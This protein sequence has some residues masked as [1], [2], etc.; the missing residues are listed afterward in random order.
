MRGPLVLA[1][2]AAAVAGWLYAHRNPSACPYSQRWLLKFP[3][4]FLTPGPVLSVLAPKPGERIL[5]IGPGTG[6][7][8]FAVAEALGSDGTLAIFD[9]QQQMLDD[10]MAEA[11]ERGVTNIEPRQGDATQLPYEDA[12]FDGAFLVTVLGEIPDG[13][14]TLRELHRV[15]KPGGRVVF[16]ETILD[17]H[18]VFPGDLRRR[19]E[20]AGF[21]H[22]HQQGIAPLGWLDRCVVQ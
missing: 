1:G 6:Y 5:E 22:D 18:I 11:R 10:V 4:P 14:T 3:R 17:P 15:L 8:S 20:A 12:S 19:A 21:R 7:H 9:L 13:D 2:G 16:G